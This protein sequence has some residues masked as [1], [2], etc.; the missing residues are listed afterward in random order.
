MIPWQ[1]EVSPLIICGA[2]R[3]HVRDPLGLRWRDVRAADGPPNTIYNRFIRWS[4]L[5]VFNRILA[6]LAA[7]S[8]ATDR[9]MIDSTHLQAHH[10]AAHLLKSRLYTDLSGVAAAA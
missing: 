7:E 5:D 8:D 4:R 9:L 3:H 2:K 10:T 6:E 1:A